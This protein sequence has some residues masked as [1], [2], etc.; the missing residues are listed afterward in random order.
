MFVVRL[1]IDFVGKPNKTSWE[2]LQI[3]IIT[4]FR[5]VD[6]AKVFKGRPKPQI[7]LHSIV[8]DFAMQ[9]RPDR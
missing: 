2:S 3:L 8:R 6:H 7:I 4:I 5:A 1:F 9:P